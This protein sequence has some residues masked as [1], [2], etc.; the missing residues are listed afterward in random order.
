MKY[1]RRTFIRQSALVGSGLLLSSLSGYAANW[2]SRGKVRK[3]GVQLWSLRDILGKDPWGL[4]AKLGESGYGSVESFEGPT[5]VYWGKTPKE[6]SA[7]LRSH[8]LSMPSIHCNVFD[9]F[10]TKV[11]E[12]AEAGVTYV[13]CP[14]LGPQKTI[15]DFKK[16]AERF[17]QMGTICKKN[18]L[19]F[20][21]H[22]HDYS[23]KELEGE[24]PQQILIEYTD[25]NLVD[26]EMDI[27]WVVAAGADPIEWFE[28]YPNRFR[29]AHIKDR[30]KK[31]VADESKNSVVIGTGHIDFKSILLAGRDKG[32]KE[33]IVEQEANYGAGPLESVVASLQY[34]ESKKF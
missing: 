23:F 25:R 5:G 17:N 8:G 14:W 3:Y 4:I 33:L 1:P 11:A 30:T 13:L 19:R 26:F 22:N 12:A 16:A 27:F 18:G 10:E 6:F 28:R 7:F 34:L 31:P 29:L 21:Y 24:I 20:G 32:L 9:R 15:D 2:L